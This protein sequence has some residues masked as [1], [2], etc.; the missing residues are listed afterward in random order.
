MLK[1]YWIQGL[2]ITFIMAFASC[3]FAAGKKE[4]NISVNVQELS[5]EK[6]SEKYGDEIYFSVVQYSNKKPAKQFRIP[7][8]P[9]YWKFKYFEKIKGINLWQGSVQNNETTQLV[10]S[11]IEQDS[12]P[13][14][15]DDHI[16]SVKVTLINKNGKLQVKWDIPNLR[17]QA[18]VLQLENNS[19]L[20]VLMGDYS[21]YKIS[22]KVIKK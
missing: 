17:D 3:I 16:G 21:K 7:E 4:L 22:F 13:L 20:F 19:P 9:S 8:F 1:S 14:D 11:I 12:F 5:V 6:L 10:I 2:L 18:E 15:L